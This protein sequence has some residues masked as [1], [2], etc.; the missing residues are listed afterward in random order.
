MSSLSE[1]LGVELVDILYSNTNL[2]YDVCAVSLIQILEH[3]TKR[4]PQ[5]ND[6]SPQVISN[7]QV[8][9]FI[10]IILKPSLINKIL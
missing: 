6:V 3:L 9:S 2:N 10:R 4:V 7:I 8:S 5:L 1:N